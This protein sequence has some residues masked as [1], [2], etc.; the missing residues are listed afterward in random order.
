MGRPLYNGPLI[1]TISYMKEREHLQEAKRKTEEMKL[2][3]FNLRTQNT[4][5]NA[6][7]S[8]MQSTISSLKDE[9]RT[10]ELNFQEKQNEAK[11]LREKYI[12]VRD[13]N[14]DQVTALT[15]LLR[16][17]EAEIEDLKQ[18][19]QL[20]AKADPSLSEI[21]PSITPENVTAKEN[22]SNSE[23]Q[24]AENGKEK[25]MMGNLG[26]IEEHKPGGENSEAHF[27]VHSK[28]LGDANLSESRESV[29]HHE[30][31]ENSNGERVRFRGKHNYAKRTKGKRLRPT[32]KKIEDGKPRNLDK[33]QDSQNESILKGH[34][35]ENNE[36]SPPGIKLIQNNTRPVV[37]TEYTMVDTS[38]NDDE[39]INSPG[40]IE[41]A[42]RYE[43]SELGNSTSIE[44]A[45]GSGE[46]SEEDKDQT[47]ETEF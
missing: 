7:I 15:E 39:R 29:N 8:D 41:V 37:D 18:R 35:G 16:R 47:D 27:T 2:K 44:S 46:D 25:E 31:Q 19:F 3:I 10:I 1:N 26:N 20:R 38:K 12:Q 42:K 13:Q 14:P 28:E 40:R 24:S 5:L 34:N 43:E 6:R 17:K 21:E 33:M 30:M 9:Q 22:I 4:E 45:H 23:E 36:D 32:G 11:L